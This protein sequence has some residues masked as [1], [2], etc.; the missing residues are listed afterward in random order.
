MIRKIQ[1]AGLN[2]YHIGEEYR[3]IT[4][5]PLHEGN[6]RDFYLDF[7]VRSIQSKLDGDFTFF[8]PRGC[9]WKDHF[10]ENRRLAK[11]IV[12]IDTKIKR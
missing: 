4:L 1:T 5:D 9:R 7:T 6:G 3:N 10:E 8:T 2:I 11:I 12:I